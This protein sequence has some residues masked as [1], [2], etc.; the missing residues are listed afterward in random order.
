MNLVPMRILAYCLM[1]NHW[2]WVLHPRA[3]GDLSRF[4]QRLTMTHTQRY[5]AKVRRWGTAT[6][7]RAATSHCW[8]NRAAIS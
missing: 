4:L 5:H 1:P 8:S 7:I 3:D 6:F 2:H